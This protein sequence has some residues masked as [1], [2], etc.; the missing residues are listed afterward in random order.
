MG[1][2]PGARKGGGGREPPEKVGCVIRVV[3]VS[4]TVRKAEEEAVRRA[5][6]EIVRAKM[7]EEKGRS[8][9]GLDK[10]LRVGQGGDSALGREEDEAGIEDMSDG[11]E[12]LDD[13]LDDDSG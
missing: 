5:R 9:G 13:D 11:E 4:G 10:L 1:S 7:T 12:D 3:R 2:L 6:T 8:K